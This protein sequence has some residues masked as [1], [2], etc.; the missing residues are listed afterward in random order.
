M[1]TLFSVENYHAESPPDWALT[2]RAAREI[3]SYF[4][5]VHAEQWIASATSE[6]FLLAGGDVGWKT[7]RVDAPDYGA[8]IKEARRAGDNMLSSFRGWNLNEEE[9]FWLIAV[10]A[11]AEPAGARLGGGGDAV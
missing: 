10:L 7:L 9:R 6:Q 11:V 1:T 4:E 3:R 8:L 5:N 2:P